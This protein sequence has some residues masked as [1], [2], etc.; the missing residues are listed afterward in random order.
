MSGE[1]INW[2]VVL[3]QESWRWNDDFSSAEQLFLVIKRN[4]KKNNI[5]NKK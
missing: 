3:K 1:Y 4:K 5:K 2:P